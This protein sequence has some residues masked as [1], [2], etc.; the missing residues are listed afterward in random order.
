MEMGTFV[1]ILLGTL[2]AGLLVEL[3]GAHEWIAVSVVVLAI[4]GWLCSRYVPVA[5]AS[6]PELQVSYNLF[7]QTRKIMKDAH[8]NKTVYMC[9]VAISWFW[10]LGAAYLTQLPNL[11]S[12]DSVGWPSGREYYAGKCLL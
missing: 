8:A 2:G 3:P 9:L 5:E 10:A 7:S 1:A 4:M 12:P 6:A 11:A